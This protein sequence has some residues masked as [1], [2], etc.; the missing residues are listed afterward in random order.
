VFLQ[1]V[2]R[3]ERLLEHVVLVPVL[4]FEFLQNLMV[5]FDH[6]FV[7]DVEPN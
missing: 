7:K 4:V 3:Q 2:E 6:Y 5:D 1:V